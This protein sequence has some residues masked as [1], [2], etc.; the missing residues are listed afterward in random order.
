MTRISRLGPRNRFRFYFCLPPP[1]MEQK[2]T[3]F[4]RNGS[5]PG[6]AW[7]FCPC[8]TIWRNRFRFFYFCPGPACAGHGLAQAPARPRRQLTRNRFPFPF[9]TFSLPLQPAGPP[10]PL[11]K[12]RP[13]FWQK[14]E[15]DLFI[16]LSN[17]FL[18]HPLKGPIKT[19]YPAKALAAF[20]QKWKALPHCKSANRF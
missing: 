4:G 13:A 14:M 9:F 15:N 3:P 18:C 19:G 7:L 12:S 1:Q 8:P 20:E 5:F 2:V 16:A 11:T 10:S 6:P 17:R